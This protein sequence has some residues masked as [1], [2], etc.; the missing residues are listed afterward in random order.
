MTSPAPHWDLQV[1]PR[2]MRYGVW[3]VASLIVTI[4]VVVS[5]LLTIRASGVIFRT[6]DR[7]A[8]IVL[9]LIVAGALLLLTR[10]RV[11]AGEAGVS[12]RN[13]LGDRL[14]PWSQVLGVTFP[15]G[16]RW[17]RLELPDDEY[18]PL[19]A[20]Q[21]ADKEHAVEAMRE[22]RALVSRYRPPS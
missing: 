13:A 1:R 17:A 14:I 11:R 6:Y 7:V 21:S 16:K 10:A 3:V 18:I 12:V 4:H 15:P 19:V 20:I 8:V 2:M 5:L 22:L 9:G